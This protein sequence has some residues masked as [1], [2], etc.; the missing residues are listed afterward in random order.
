MNE[1]ELRQQ[2]RERLERARTLRDEIRVD[3]HLA[4]MELKERWRDLEPTMRDAERL[5]E[6]VS[7]VA[8]AAL[9]DIVERFQAFRDT[10]RER[11][12]SD[13]RPHL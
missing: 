4:G 9:D 8:R 13:T 3:V 6:Q 7:E 11:R 1:T 2:V 10:V 12:A 5:G